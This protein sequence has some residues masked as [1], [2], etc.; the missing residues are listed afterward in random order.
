[1]SL[2]KKIDGITKEREL[3]Y[4]EY[5]KNK[6]NITENNTNGNNDRSKA[7]KIEGLDEIIKE[8]EEENEKFLRGSPDAEVFVEILEKKESLKELMKS[9]GKT[10]ENLQ[11]I[12]TRIKEFY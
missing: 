12:F 7:I 10:K 2:K 11:S 4:N 9:F 6:Q 3:Y 8:I 5:M 1:M